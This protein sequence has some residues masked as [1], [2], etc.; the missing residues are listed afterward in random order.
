MAFFVHILLIYDVDFTH[1]CK[2]ITAPQ[3]NLKN[4]NKSILYL[5]YSLN[6]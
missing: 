4:S 6:R 3:K 2:K 1:A 5:K